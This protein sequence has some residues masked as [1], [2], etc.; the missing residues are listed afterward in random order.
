MYNINPTQT[1]QHLL[2]MFSY[3]FKTV[4]KTKPTQIP[5]SIFMFN[6]ENLNHSIKCNHRRCN[7]SYFEF[8]LVNS[9]HLNLALTNLYINFNDLKLLTKIA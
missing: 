6:F 4:C 7:F 3:R 9:I 5:K 1:K 2:G 8:L